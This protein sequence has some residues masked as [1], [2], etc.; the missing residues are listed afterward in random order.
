MTNAFVEKLRGFAPVSDTDA[1]LLHKLSRNSRDVP[2][3]HDLIREGTEPGPIIVVLSGW[4]CRY[5]LLPDGSRQIIAFMMPGDFCDI[6]AGILAE[7]D[8]SIATLT[9]ATIALI[10]RAELEAVLE[11]RPSLGKAFWWTQLVDEGVLRATIVSMGRRTSTERIA[12]LLCELY[13]RML[14]MGLANRNSC[15]MPFSQIVLADAVG[16]TPIHTNRV[17]KKL[18][19]AGAMEIGPGTIAIAN[20]AHLAEIAGFD[21]NYLHYRLKKGQHELTRLQYPLGEKR[22]PH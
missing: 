22:G 21:D 19:S 10:P 2:A 7:M 18:R 9:P 20:I 12:H 17:I 8:H 1:Q 4:A 5:K 6:H 16:L 14:H 13:F 15:I 3:S 11:E